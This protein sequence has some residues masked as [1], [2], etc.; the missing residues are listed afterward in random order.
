MEIEGHT[1]DQGGEEKEAAGELRAGEEK[2]Q[3]VHPG[4]RAQQDAEGPE[5]GQIPQLSGQ[6]ADRGENQEVA[7]PVGE[8]IQVVQ[9]EVQMD[10]KIGPGDAAQGAPNTCVIHGVTSAGSAVQV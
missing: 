7:R 5:Q 9:A 10:E 2:G 3:P 8:Q 6:Q 1:G 4:H